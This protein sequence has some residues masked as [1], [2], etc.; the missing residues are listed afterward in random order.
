MSYWLDIGYEVKLQSGKELPVDGL[1]GCPVAG[2]DEVNAELM[3]STNCTEKCYEVDFCPE[4][5]M[6]LSK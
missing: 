1:K 6:P 3:N 4:W 5:K 2:L